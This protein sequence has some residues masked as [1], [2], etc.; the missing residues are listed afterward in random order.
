MRP[1][2]WEQKNRK[3]SAEKERARRL[4]KGDEIRAKD[5]ARYAANPQRKLGASKKWRTANPGKKRAAARRWQGLP[6]PTRPEPLHCE[7]CARQFEK[8]PH[9]DHDHATGE[10]RGWLCGSC[11]GGLGLFRDSIDTLQHAIAYL[12]K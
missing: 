7:I 5:R 6:E 2:N 9:L 11:N 10:F 8:T 3:Y 1:R 4:A 12:T